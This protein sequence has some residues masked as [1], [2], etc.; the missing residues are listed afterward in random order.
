MNIVGHGLDIVEISY[1]RRL[2]EDASGDAALKRCFTRSELT[3]LE[4]DIDRAARLAGR[5]AAK[6]ALLKALGSGWTQ[7]IALTDIEINALPTGAPIVTVTGRVASLADERNVTSW[8]L[9][10]SHTD[11]IA[12]ASVIAISHAEDS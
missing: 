2:C 1:F 7:G 4:G 12:A 3:L 11:V 5:F 8:L 6:E 9:S 10:I